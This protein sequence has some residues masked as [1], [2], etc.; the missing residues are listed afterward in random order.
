MARLDNQSASALTNLAYDKLLEKLHDY[1]NQ[2]GQQQRIALLKMQTAFTR[3]AQGEFTG[4]HAF[5][6]PTGAGKTQSVV[7]FIASLAQLGIDNVSIAVCASK[8][9]ALCD[10][11]RDLLLQG[12]PEEKIGLLHSYKFDAEKAKEYLESGKDLPPNYASLPCTDN[13]DMKQFV[14][15][16]HERVRGKGGLEQYN[17]YRGEPRSLLIWDESLLTSDARSIEAIKLNQAIGYIAP[18]IDEGRASEV[19]KMAYKYLRDAVDILHGE[20][21][22]I[23]NSAKSPEQITLPKLTG[24]E[25]RDFKKVLGENQACEPLKDLLDMSQNP[26]RAVI[27]QQGTGIITYE[28][29]VPKELKNIIILDASHPIRE[30]V[31]LDKSIRQAET[32]VGISYENVTVYQMDHPSGRSTM[33][34]H[35]RQTRPNRTLSREICKV[36]KS[37]PANEAVLIWIFKKKFHVDFQDILLLDLKNAGIDVDAKFKI[38]TW[39]DGKLHY[40]E[41]PRLNFLTWG[42]ETSL[43]KYSYC[44]NVI[45]AGVLHRSHIELASKMAGQADNL[46]SP[47]EG[48][49]IKEIEQ[50]ECA[51]CIH[52][53]MSRGSCRIIEDGK[54]KPMRA[55]LIHPGKKV[56][57]ELEKVMP[58]IKWKEWETET[59]KPKGKIKELSEQLSGYLKKLAPGVLSIPT[60]KLKAYLGLDVHPNTFTQAAKLVSQDETGFQYE[61]RSFKRVMDQAA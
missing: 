61:G 31:Q 17:L 40:E 11:K 21:K 53:A 19:L 59:A 54:T 1:G 37:I 58:G 4:R 57:G 39:L 28:I 46:T 5:A 43:S 26:L 47:L 34:E 23:R 41:K 29:V 48:K 51:Y 52:Q 16:T 25:I 35:F 36:V 8:V 60:R 20:I 50:S 49:T 14:L 44:S 9:E 33:E 30:L 2:P 42:N 10:L 55:W 18:L 15:C 3:M 24:E 56:R 27:T 7:A 45:F 32:D 13:N 38:P 22:A 6:L 12:V